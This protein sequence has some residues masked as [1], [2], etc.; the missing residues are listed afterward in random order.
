MKFTTMPIPCT[1]KERTDT[2]QLFIELLMQVNFMRK[3]NMRKMQLQLATTSNYVKETYSSNKNKIEKYFEEV[4]RCATIEWD[5]N[6]KSYYCS[7]RYLSLRVASHG[8]AWIIINNHRE[9][10]ISYSY[11]HVGSSGNCVSLF[12]MP[13]FMLQILPMKFDIYLH[14]FPFVWR[15]AK[16]K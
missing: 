16:Y 11:S 14:D 6:C 13:L 8:M 7:S 2:D 9:Y 15:S 5:S 1:D 10:S 4:R 3:S 12:R